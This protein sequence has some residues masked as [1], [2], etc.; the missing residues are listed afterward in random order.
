M[1]KPIRE[2]KI[3]VC[4]LMMFSLITLSSCGNVVGTFWV[5]NLLFENGLITEDNLKNVAA[6]RNGS[7]QK[8]VDYS[9]NPIELE[10]IEYEVTPITDDLSKDQTKKIVNSFN[11]EINNNYKA[12]NSSARVNTSELIAYYG[13]YNG[14][15]IV[16]FE[17][18][19]K[20][21]DVVGETYDFIVADYYFGLLPANCVVWA[22]S[23]NSL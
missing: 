8:V 5:L 12:I 7:L 17:Y 2:H 19:L 4:L 6:L 9:A 11:N 20:D 10:T 23:E 3:S 16:E 13:T 22:W 21:Y 18:S 14:F 1:L 15:S